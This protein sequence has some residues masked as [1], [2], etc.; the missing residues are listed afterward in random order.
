[1]KC[2]L[3]RCNTSILMIDI[4]HFSLFNDSYGHEAGDLVLEKLG[5]FL[6]TNI[7]SQDIACRYGGEEFLLILSE[8]TLEDA[9]QRAEELRLG[10]KKFGSRI[11][12]QR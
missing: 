10:V 6:R 1:M 12:A 9:R 5:A 7:R 8:V 3:E 2:C 4:D 11:E